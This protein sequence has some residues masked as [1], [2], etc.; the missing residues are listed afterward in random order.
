ME[1]KWIKEKDNLTILIVNEKK[2][3]EEIGRIYGCSG[4]NIKKVAQ[5]LGIELTPR[6]EINECE[7]FNRKSSMNICKNCGKEFVKYPGHSGNFCCLECSN[8][9][10]HKQA[11]KN[12]LENPDKYC[13]GNY[14]PRSFKD[15]ILKEQGCKCAICGCSTKWNGKTLV[16]VLDHIDG[17]ASHNYRENLRMICPNCDSQLPTYKSKNKNGDRHYYRYHKEKNRVQ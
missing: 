5:R 17:H 2:S 6:R 16:F 13:R 1:S 3:Y 10:R 9:Y 4:N 7:T 11:Y 14:Q 8:E 15:D 12:F